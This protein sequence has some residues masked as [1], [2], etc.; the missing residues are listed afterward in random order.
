MTDALEM[1]ALA[2]EGFEE[3][4]RRV[5]DGNWQRP[6]PCA[7]WDVY[8]LVNHVVVGGASPQVSRCR[9]ARQ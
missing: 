5:G 7:E 6:T 1:L 9:R 2:D 3:R 4:L 8:R